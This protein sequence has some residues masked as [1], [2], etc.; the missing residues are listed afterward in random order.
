M[1]WLLWC[2]WVAGLW[3]W[4]GAAW[5]SLKERWRKAMP[6]TAATAMAC[7]GTGSLSW[8]T[9]TKRTMRKGWPRYRGGAAA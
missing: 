8:T 1:V 6:T 5:W 7:E 4:E 3:W 9:K 2:W